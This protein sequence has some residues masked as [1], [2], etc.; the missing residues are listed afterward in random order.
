MI[1]SIYLPFSLG[2]SHVLFTKYSTNLDF[3]WMEAYNGAY[4]R[5]KALWLGVEQGRSLSMC[6]YLY[7]CPRFIVLLEIN[8][9]IKAFQ[10]H[11]FIDSIAWCL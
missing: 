5:W 2:I 11:G 1:V 8:C 6:L 3:R 4:I 7:F 9:T 10:F